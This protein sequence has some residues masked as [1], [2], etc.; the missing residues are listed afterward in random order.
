MAWSRKSA[1]FGSLAI[2]LYL[3][4]LTLRNHQLVTVAVVLL[5]FLTWA[6]LRASHA[7]VAASGRRMEERSDE[8][9]G[10]SLSRLSA[11]RKLSSARVFEDGEVDVTLRIQNHSPLSK[12]LEVR[13]SLPEVMRI[14]KGANY[15]LMELGPRRETLI[16]YTVECPLRGFY[17]IGPVCIRIQDSFGLFH[18][19]K[20]MHVYDD[21][22][23]FPKTEDLKDAFV[24]SK[25]PKIFTGAVNIRQPGPGSEFYNLREY[26]AGDPMKAINWAAT[27]RSG[28][29]MM[30]N[31]RERDAVSD[32]I[33]ILDSRAVS[34]TGPVSRNSLVYGTRAAASLASFF[35]SRRDSVGLVVYGDEVLSVDRDT[36]KK[37]LYVILTKLAG[38]MA[39]GETPLQVVTNRILPHINK[40]SPIIILSCLEDD[41]TIV[42]AVRDLRARHFDTTMLSPSSLEFEFDARRLD[43]TGYEVLKTERDILISEL[44]GLG[45]FVMDWEPD[46]LLAT[47]LSG[48]RGF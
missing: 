38:A 1:M 18:K 20:E 47:A 13:D 45:A 22:L 8:E 31:E 3:L 26:I 34:E 16:E 32:I 42:S 10:V 48:A 4:G 27:A 5:S 12:V 24:K 11:M 21:F 44:R 23:V 43:R 15:I 7:D 37:Q 36:G 29:K 30:V 41:S 6:A 25:V 9:G 33:L 39:R 35:L 2:A 17:T 46:M 19:E 28:G 40:G 14:K